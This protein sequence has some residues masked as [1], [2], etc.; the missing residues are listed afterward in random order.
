MQLQA[1]VWNNWIHFP[2]CAKWNIFYRV[3][4]DQFMII[5]NEELNEGTRKASPPKQM[6]HCHSDQWGA[7]HPWY[8]DQMNYRVEL[9]TPSH[10]WAP[11]TVRSWNFSTIWKAIKINEQ[12]LDPRIKIKQ[13]NYLTRVRIDRCT[14]KNH[15]KLHLI[16]DTK[17]I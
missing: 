14:P 3:R 11:K 2:K 15:L 12:W 6:A 13:Q 17:T 7:F 9:F 16:P 8:E 1:N 10:S 5:T 4:T